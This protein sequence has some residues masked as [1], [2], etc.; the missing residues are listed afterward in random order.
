MMNESLDESKRL[1]NESP[2]FLIYNANLPNFLWGDR[3]TPPTHSPSPPYLIT[4]FEDETH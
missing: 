1:M 3:A 2:L 4:F